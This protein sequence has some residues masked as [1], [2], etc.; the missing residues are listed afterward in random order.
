M[1][2]A[3]L[4]R[5]LIA[6]YGVVI[7]G[8]SVLYSMEELGRIGYA[9]DDYRRWYAAWQ[10]FEEDPL[11]R[12]FK[13]I[14]NDVVHPNNRMVGI[15]LIDWSADADRR[16]RPAGEITFDALEPPATHRGTVITD[17]SMK[18]LCGLYLEHLH[19]MLD[20]FAPVAFAVSDRR[21][22]QLHAR[23]ERIARG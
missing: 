5:V 11:V 19:E 7:F 17:H 16:V 9:D 12:Y 4:D 13:R 8:R 15:V 3:D 18:A 23:R 20:T 1:A 6:F 14:R 10:P 2:T 21:L 22:A